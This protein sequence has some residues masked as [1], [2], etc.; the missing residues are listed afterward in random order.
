MKTCH[1]EVCFS[2]TCCNVVISDFQA[3]NWQICMLTQVQT[4]GV[5]VI[6]PIWSRRRWVASPTS[7]P[8]QRIHW[9]GKGV[10][11]WAMMALIK[12]YE[13]FLG[14]YKP[15][16]EISDNTVQSHSANL[17][18][19]AL[20]ARVCSESADPPTEIWKDI[21]EEKCEDKYSNTPNTP[22]L[23]G[24]WTC[25]YIQESYNA[26]VTNWATSYLRLAI[27]TTSHLRHLKP[28]LLSKWVQLKFAP[29]DMS[30]VAKE[31]QKIAEGVS[32]VV[33]EAWILSHSNM[34]SAKV[35]RLTDARCQQISQVLKV[36]FSISLVSSN[37]LQNLQKISPKKQSKEQSKST[38]HSL[39]FGDRQESTIA[40][41]S[42][43]CFGTE[44]RPEISEIQNL[45]SFL[46]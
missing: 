31:S 42:V 12:K 25:T 9:V 36:V 37:H 29:L 7:I 35:Q 19:K 2:M 10:G 33:H 6:W 39:P 45:G 27:K 26:T 16:K 24:H 8:R 13:A 11:R 28:W 32:V 34:L 15:F 4:S 46:K 20:L 23:R 41:Q 1:T 43:R 22:K 44:G 17:W 18:R 40:L 21:G 5:K 14:H 30:F 38:V 3:A